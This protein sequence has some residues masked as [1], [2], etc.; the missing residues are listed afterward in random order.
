MEML[1]KCLREALEE[2][3]QRRQLRVVVAPGDLGGLHDLDEVVVR[4]AEQRRR[5][6][7]RTRWPPTGRR[8]WGRWG[9]AAKQKLRSATREGVGQRVEEGHVGLVVVAHGALAVDGVAAVLVVVDDEAVHL[10]VVPLA[11]RLVPAV[12]G[13][14]EAVLGLVEELDGR[15][16]GVGVGGVER[17][18]VGVGLHG[19]EVAEQVIEGAV[20][21]HHDDEGVDGDLRAER[22]VL[23]Q[24]QAGQRAGLEGARLARGLRLRRRCRRCA[25]PRREDCSHR[26]QTAGASKVRW[27]MGGMLRSDVIVARRDRAAN[28][29]RPL[30][31]HRRDRREGGARGA[32]AVH[33]RAG[34]TCACTRACGWRRR[35]AAS[36][37]APSRR[38]RWWCSPSSP[39]RTASSCAACATRRTSTPSTSSAR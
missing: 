37:T 13:I 8:G 11:V 36:S 18:D 7:G 3:A 29:L 9:R 39:P 21:H 24:R 5:R 19:L 32:A 15:A 4:I 10:A 30:G 28:H 20:L 17:R 26:R 16:V 2:D 14:V 35:C 22:R 31:R 25:A 27:R 38:A 1:S 6:P 23:G 12:V 33:Q 34:A